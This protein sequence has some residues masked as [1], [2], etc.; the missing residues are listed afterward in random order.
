MR[1]HRVVLREYIRNL[2]SGKV[3]IVMPEIDGVSNVRSGCERFARLR[4][5]F[6]KKLT[7]LKRSVALHYAHNDFVHC[8][9]T[10]RST[11]AMAGRL[12]DKLF[13]MRDLVDA[14]VISSDSAAVAR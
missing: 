2:F 14:S 4:L 6:S 11:P 1:C 3:N 9:S 7:N 13:S 10:P 12:S 5:A 8:D